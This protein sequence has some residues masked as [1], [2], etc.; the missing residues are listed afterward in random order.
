MVCSGFQGGCTCENVPLLRVDI[1]NVEIAACCAPRPLMLISCTGDWTSE[2]PKYDAP[3][4]QKVFDFLGVPERFRSFQDAADH[5]YNKNS[6]EAAYAWLARW[7]QGAPDAERVPEPS[8]T[9]E[10]RE[11]LAVYSEAHP[12]PPGVDAG[13]LVEL[14]RGVASGQL[15]PRDAATLGTFRKLMEPA[16]RH[17]LTA[18]WPEPGDVEAVAEHPEK[19]LL[20]RRGLAGTVELAIVR[21]S[22]GKGPSTLIVAPESEGVEALTADGCVAVLRVRPH[23]R[24]EATVKSENGETEIYATTFYRTALSWRV[25]DILTCLAYLSE[26][27]SLRL[28]GLGEAG[29]PTLFAGALAPVSVTVADVSGINDAD[30]ASWTGD[31]AHPGILRVGGLRTAGMLYA[32]GK[33][34]LV[35]HNTQA[36]F[37]T[38]S[39]AAAFEA[40]G[41]ADALTLSEERYGKLAWEGVE[42]ILE[43]LK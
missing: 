27:E 24:R 1:N 22:P 41:R 15:G 25:Q 23:E 6:R 19:V 7:L 8:F 5:N 21:G 36:T 33:G 14:L 4:L 12:R 16:L 26:A 2:V 43:A 40:A 37:D 18:G 42:K 9:A 32:S 13:A 34:R 30:E 11:D 29:V 28:V 38:S 31:L 39:I 17:T 35:I 20:V 3:V 10:P